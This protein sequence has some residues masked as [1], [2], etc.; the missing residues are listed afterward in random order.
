M[1]RA[2]QAAVVALLLGGPVV[3]QSASR[4]LPASYRPGGAA[5]TVSVTLAGIGSVTAVGAEDKPPSGWTVSNISNGGAFDGQSGKVKWGPFFSPSIPSTLTYD[6][7]APVDA[8]GEACFVGTASFDGLD[9]PVGGEQC[10]PAPIP[11]TSTAGLLLF[12]AL[13]TSLGGLVLT[14]RRCDRR[15]SEL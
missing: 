6:I 8:S 2:L 9:Q 4:E 1:R 15:H 5:Q 12:G 14:R 10:I 13:L 11:A 7:A 3:A